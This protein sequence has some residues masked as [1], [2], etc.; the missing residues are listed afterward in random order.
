MSGTSIMKKYFF[1]ILIFLCAFAHAANVVHEYKLPNGLKLLVK[2]DHRTPIAITQVWYK[3]GSSYEPPG[4]T[5]ISHALEHMMFRGSKNYSATQFLQTIAE[6]GAQQNAMTDYDYTTYYE[7]MGADKLPISF[8][9]EADRMR[10]LLLNEQDFAKEIQ[11]VMEERRMRT[12]D[13]PQALT[14]E[15]FLAAAHI[16][17][18]YHHPVIGWMT[19]LVNMN[20]NDLRRWY[21]T[22]YAP[23]NAIVVVVGDVKPDQVYELAKKY[24]GPLQPAQLPVVKPQ[25]E[26]KS[27]GTRIV[28]VAAPAKLPF[29]IMGYN[30]PS[31]KTATEKWQPYALE[32]LADILGGGDS[33][34]LQKNLVRG[35]QL[36]SNINVDYGAYSRLDD[37]LTINAVPAA[38]H[39]ITDLRDA[40]E[41]E[42][43]SLQN[44]PVSNAE[45]E[46]V[47]AQIVANKVYQEDDIAYQANEI[48]RLEV[49]GLPWQE[50]DRGMEMLKNVTAAQVQAVTKQYLTPENLTIGI[51]KPLPMSEKQQQKQSLPNT[52]GTYVH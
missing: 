44:T 40:I 26:L 36:A 1:F 19:D 41:K 34:R 23:N 14:N 46:R 50:I 39:S 21:Q 24:F 17:N 22:W 29:L 4:I 49:I 48:G 15:R 28:N 45:L 7:L 32:V 47:K 35:K 51:L 5:G 2:E 42:I 16:A 33:S 43:Y 25:S 9:L 12:D 13:D 6:N 20:V 31:V 11:V 3:V 18:S 52:R 10:N 37:L 27:L 8:K 38:G 30:T